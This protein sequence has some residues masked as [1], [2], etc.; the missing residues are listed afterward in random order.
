VLSRQIDEDRTEQLPVVVLQSKEAT[1]PGQGRA[2]VWLDEAG[3]AGLFDA[4]GAPKSEISKLLAAGA[5]VV[6]VDLLFQ[7][8]FLADGKPIARTRRV[9]NTRESAAYTFGYNHTLFAR[10]VHDVLSTIALLQSRR[11]APVA[12]DLVAFGKSGPLAA[13]ARAVAGGAVERLAIDTGGFRFG[14][15]SDIHDVDFLPGGAKYFDLPGMLSLSAPHK[16]WIAGEG[17]QPPKIVKA[18]YEAAGAEKNVIAFA[19]SPG[20]QADAAVKWLIVV[21][22][23]ANKRL[24]A[25]RTTTMKESNPP[26]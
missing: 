5:T 24:F 18:A 12:V 16:L 4:G 6:G 10:R 22:R 9:A 13:A 19:G 2:V 21:V 25:E 23:S 15:L 17:D 20:D 7:G 14:K 26:L 8:E 3:K 1:W 11:E